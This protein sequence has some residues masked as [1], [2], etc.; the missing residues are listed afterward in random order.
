MLYSFLKYHFLRSLSSDF[1]SHPSAP[2]D[3]IINNLLK[4]QKLPPLP[5][6]QDMNLTA[7]DTA[8]SFPNSLPIYP[9]LPGTQFGFASSHVFRGAWPCLVPGNESQLN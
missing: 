3:H 2:N 5:T 8:Y 4:E 7:A 9:L 6:S 1:H